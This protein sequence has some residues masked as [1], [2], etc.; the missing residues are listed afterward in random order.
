MTTIKVKNE[1]EIIKKLSSYV[2]KISNDAIVN[3]GRFY[4]G[5]SGDYIFFATFVTFKVKLIKM[6]R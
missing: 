2:E 4:I 3:R 6:Q 1:Q 5:L